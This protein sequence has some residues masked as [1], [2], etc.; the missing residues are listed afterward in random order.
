MDVTVMN[1]AQ[2]YREL[3]AYLESHRARLGESEVVRVS[4]TSAADQARLRRHEFE[5]GF[6][7]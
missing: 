6:I 4:G 2:G 1:S 7:A 5:V 3:V